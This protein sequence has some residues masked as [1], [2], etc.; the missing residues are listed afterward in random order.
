MKRIIVL[1]ISI[2]LFIIGCE[3]PSSKDQNPSTMEA[4]YNGTSILFTNE[5][6]T[7]INLAGLEDVLNPT[8]SVNFGTSTLNNS[9]TIHYSWIVT[10]ATP[11]VN[12]T[13]TFTSSIIAYASSASGN[14]TASSSFIISTSPDL[15]D[16]WTVLD[17][18]SETNNIIIG[19]NGVDA[20]MTIANNYTPMLTVRKMK[21]TVYCDVLGEDVAYRG[22]ILSKILAE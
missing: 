3:Q 20:G 11:I 1:L 16:S 8:S 12:P 9:G 10:L 13:V 15:S 19:K 5:S 4:S 14:Q 18:Q 17:Q 21:L 7:L 2:S 6:S 22:V